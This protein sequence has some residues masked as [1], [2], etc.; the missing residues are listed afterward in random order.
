LKGTVDT[1]FLRREQGVSELALRPLVEE[2][3][4]VILP[5][6]HRLAALKAISPGDHGSVLNS[7]DGRRRAVACLRTELSHFVRNE[8][9]SEGRRTDCRAGP[10]VQ[11]VELVSRPKASALEI[12]RVGRSCLEEDPTKLGMH[13]SAPRF[14]RVR[15]ARRLQR[16]SLCLW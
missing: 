9:P 12:G 3:L 11:K 13:L 10:R 5:S 8:S 16:V 15:L 7:V 2:P 4:V 6:D 1:A 14:F